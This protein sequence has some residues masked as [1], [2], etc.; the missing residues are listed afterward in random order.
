MGDGAN[1]SGGMRWTGEIG[2]GSILALAQLATLAAGGI[3]FYAKLDNTAQNTAA[4][5]LELRHIVTKQEDRT[6]GINDRL[7]KVETVQTNTAEAVT[8]IESKVDALGRAVTRSP[9]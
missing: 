2:I 3:W 1:G 5:A 8:R 7:I 4:T 9:N 6:G